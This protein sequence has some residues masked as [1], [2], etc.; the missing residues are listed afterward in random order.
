MITIQCF[1]PKKSPFSCT[2]QKKTLPL[3]RKGQNK[4]TRY[5]TT[6]SQTTTNWTLE[7]GAM[8][9]VL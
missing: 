4:R 9:L 8:L 3:R 5:A 2:A 7:A 1:V 6:T